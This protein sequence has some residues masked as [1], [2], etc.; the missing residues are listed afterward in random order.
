[1]QEYGGDLVGSSVVEVVLAVVPRRRHKPPSSWTARSC[2]MGFVG[3][4]LSFVFYRLS[5]TWL[6]VSD[7]YRSPEWC[8]EPQPI[9]LWGLYVTYVV[10]RLRR[11]SGSIVMRIWTR[12][13]TVDSELKL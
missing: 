9:G 1:M 3:C 4:I 7:Q 6:Y 5:K 13:H 8:C 2:C 12:A 11:R 10:G